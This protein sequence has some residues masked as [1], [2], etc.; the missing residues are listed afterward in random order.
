MLREGPEHCYVSRLFD[1]RPLLRCEDKLHAN[2]ISYGRQ[3]ADYCA[4]MLEACPSVFRIFMPKGSH[5]GQHLW[6]QVFL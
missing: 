2:R 3:D 4:S 1:P 6:A 5:V